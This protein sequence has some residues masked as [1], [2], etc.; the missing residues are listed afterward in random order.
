MWEIPLEYIVAETEMQRREKDEATVILQASEVSSVQTRLRA[1][2][3]LRPL[4]RRRPAARIGGIA[5]A[6]ADFKGM[7]GCSFSLVY[8]KDACLG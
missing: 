2:L 6:I 8:G 3:H 7:L 4:P 1:A 5:V